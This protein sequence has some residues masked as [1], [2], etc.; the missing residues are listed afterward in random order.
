METQIDIWLDR[1]TCYY[2]G[3]I[4]ICEYQIRPTKPFVID[5]IEVSVLWATEGKGQTD[6]G[7]HFFERKRSPRAQAYTGKQKLTTVLPETP[8]S[9]RGLILKVNWY[10]RVKL[11]SNDGQSLI[12]DEPFLLGPGCFFESAR[13]IEAEA[14]DDPH[15]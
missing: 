14:V 13:K 3:D 10:V 11:F 7:V 1:R 5:A 8:L 15:A 12:E 4:L 9:Y 2:P 6:I